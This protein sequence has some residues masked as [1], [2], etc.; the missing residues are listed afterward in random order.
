MTGSVPDASAGTEAGR[1]KKGKVLG[2]RSG[3]PPC[4]PERL[5][6][7]TPLRPPL[8]KVVEQHVLRLHPQ[9]IEHLTTG[10]EHE[11]WAAEVVLDV[12][13]CR[14]VLEIV[15]VDHLVDKAGEA[16][17]IVLGKRLGESQVLFEVVVFPR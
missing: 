17:P 7:P 14:V 1:F 9:I 12:L 11:R 13:G 3:R 4:R 5:E 16:G 6:V 15:V 10:L 8:P 2:R